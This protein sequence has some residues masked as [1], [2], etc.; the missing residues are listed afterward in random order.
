MFLLCVI[1]SLSYLSAQNS[2]FKNNPAGSWK[3]DFPNGS[4]GYQVGIMK[5]NLVDQ[6]YNVSVFLV[7]T[8]NKVIGYNVKFAADTLRYNLYLE[9]ADVSVTLKFDAADKMSGN[10]VYS[11]GAVPLIMTRQ[12]Q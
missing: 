4:E 2:Q 1:F 6:K 10:A 3:F 9:S 5:V 12:K 8:I 7:D 11:E